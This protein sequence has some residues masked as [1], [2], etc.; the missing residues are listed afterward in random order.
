MRPSMFM[1]GSGLPR[2]KYVGSY[3]QPS[4]GTPVGSALFQNI[5]GLDPE[6]YVFVVCATNSAS[7]Y[8]TTPDT[9]W[10][11]DNF[12]FGAGY[13]TTV[14]RRKSPTAL[15]IYGSGSAYG[16][17]M[18]AYRGVSR[19]TRRSVLEA[20]YTSGNIIVPGFARNGD[21]VG[22]VSV[23]ETR[24]EGLTT[25]SPSSGFTRRAISTPG[26]FTQTFADALAKAD[27]VDGASVTW[28]SITD[29]RVGMLYE[30]RI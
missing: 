23:A 4:V 8:F 21:C 5:P 26:N 10:E 6:D 30:M 19:V 20:P 12:A 18:F 24:A 9:G 16:A 15:S 3:F 14:F 27:Y 11:V 2:A 22:V 29:Y 25:V 28:S 17:M 13:R 7:A 1:G